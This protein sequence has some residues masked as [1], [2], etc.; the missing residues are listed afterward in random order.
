MTNYRLTLPTGQVFF[1]DT[2][3]LT[4][5]YDPQ[6]QPASGDRRVVLEFGF[7]TSGAVDAKYNEMIQVGYG[8]YL[9]VR[10]LFGARYALI[11]DPDGNQIGL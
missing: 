5:S 9:G 7:A 6:W 11:I 1:W 4:R 8:S 2:Y 10:D 3:T